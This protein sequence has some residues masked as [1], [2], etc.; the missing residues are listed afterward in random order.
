MVLDLLF[1][2]DLWHVKVLP[3]FSVI[4][5]NNDLKLFVDLFFYIK[6]MFYIIVY[7]KTFY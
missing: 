1:D 5:T 4:E 2:G 3:S 6:A 7:L